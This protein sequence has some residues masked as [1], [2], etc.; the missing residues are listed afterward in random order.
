MPAVRPFWLRPVQRGADSSM[1]NL[2]IDGTAV[3]ARE[4]MTILEA[5]RQA[6]I[7]IPSLCYLKGINQIGACRVCVVEIEGIERL[8]PAC[9]NQVTEGM[10][11][12]TN[13]PRVRRARKTNLKLIL[14][15]HDGNCTACG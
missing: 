2:T 9:D 7:H 5:A 15:Q 14:S 12:H 8:V 1:V 13:S 10:V 11:V 3:T 6:K 4:G